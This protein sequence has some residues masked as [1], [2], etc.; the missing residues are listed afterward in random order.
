MRKNNLTVALFWT[1]SLESKGAQTNVDLAKKI[2]KCVSYV[3]FLRLQRIDSISK[4]YT[5]RKQTQISQNLK[6]ENIWS[7]CSTSSN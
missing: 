4:I 1:I 7:N 3:P 5:S 2:I 6:G